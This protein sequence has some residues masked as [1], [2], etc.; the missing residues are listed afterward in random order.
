M[1][2]RFTAGQAFRSCVRSQQ[3]FRTL[4]Y[5]PHPC[6]RTL[7][8]RSTADSLLLE[9][10][11]NGTASASRTCLRCHRRAVNE[12]M[13]GVGGK[14]G[15]GEIPARPVSTPGYPGS[16]SRCGGRQRGNAKSLTGRGAGRVRNGVDPRR[17]QCVRAGN[18]GFGVALNDRADAARAGRDRRTQ[19]S[20]SS[21]CSNSSR[22]Q[23]LAGFSRRSM[24]RYRSSRS[25]RCSRM[26]S[27]A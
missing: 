17:W 15:D 26:A 7:H 9:L 1:L 16:R 18:G 22:L 8:L 6:G 5:L 25:S 19:P 20:R 2:G 12:K 23:R 21:S 24:D 13:V 11:Y 14:P 4:L 27:R 10:N 3:S